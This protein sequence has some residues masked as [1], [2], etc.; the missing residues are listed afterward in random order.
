M[1]DKEI[2]IVPIR[3]LIIVLRWLD[4]QSELCAYKISETHKVGRWKGMCRPLF[5]IV[6]S[7]L[8]IPD[9]PC[10]LAVI[11]IFFFAFVLIYNN[12]W[13]WA[14]VGLANLCL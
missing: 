4:L 7:P 9:A 2:S 10:W 13:R 12:Y 8:I 11:I 1:N 6:R 3:T 14:V 5:G